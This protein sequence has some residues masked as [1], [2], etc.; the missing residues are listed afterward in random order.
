[1]D[2]MELH[3]RRVPIGVLRLARDS[4]KTVAPWIGHRG[5]PA[6]I[7][8]SV[9][10]VVLTGHWRRGR[11]VDACLARTLAQ[12]GF[13]ADALESLATF[14]GPL[15]PKSASACDYRV[16]GY[17]ASTRRVHA[18]LVFRKP[19]SGPLIIGRGRFAGLGLFIPAD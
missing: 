17:L 14:T 12:Q 19:I 4:A 3:D 11:S 8:R 13:P 10:P 9:T 16:H 2:G 18:E 5:A 1:V 7:W 6:R 15:V